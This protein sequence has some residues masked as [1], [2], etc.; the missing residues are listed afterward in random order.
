MKLIA[1]LI[2]LLPLASGIFNG[3][4]CNIIT[5]KSA[6]I[7]ACAATI[8]AAIL[9]TG[10]F[11][12]LGSN[13]IH[14]TLHR[15]FNITQVNVNW[16][17]YID[18]LS[19]IMFVIVTWI[20]ALVHI[21]SLGYMHDD[22][23]LPKFLSFLSFF[24]FFMLMLVSAD[25]FI[26]LF[27]GWEG[28]G[29]CSYLLIGYWYKRPAANAASIKAFVVNR[30]SDFAF[31]LGIFAIIVYSNNVNFEEVFAK[32]QSLSELKLSSFGFNYSVL[33]VI[34]FLLLVG[35]MGKS[36]QI[37]FHVW[38]PDAMEGPTP[39]SA[40]IHAATMVTAGIFLLARCSYIFEYSP[41][42]LQVVTIVGAITCLFAAS[43]AVAQVDIKK[44]I[45]YS[46]CSQ[47]GYMFFS[48]GISAYQASIFHLAT[49]AFFKAL[50]FLA[51][52]N[53][54]HAC[55]QQNIFEM[56][57]LRKKMPITYIG[58]WV[59][60]LAI[61]GI[62]PLAGFYSKDLILEFAF[63]SFGAGQ[64]GFYFGIITAVL[65]AIYSMKMII[66]VFHG[67]TRL[68]SDI[69][70]N[71]SE[72]PATMNIP[73]IILGLG[74][75]VTGMI[76]YYVL[77][78]YEVGTSTFFANSILNLRF[79]NKHVS[80]LVEMLPLGAGIAGILIAFSFYRNEKCKLNN[81]TK[82][83]NNLL[84]N[85]YY[86]DEIYDYLVVRNIK[87]LSDS[88]DII[89]K[90]LIDKFG[91]IGVSGII[92]IMA[93]KVSSFQTGYIFNY[94]LIISFALLICL[95]CFLINFVVKI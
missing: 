47:L 22:E 17:I 56:G 49:H 29:L 54:I 48:C 83:V 16:A 42:I 50:L 45:A 14:V 38:L 26:Q 86:F 64:L 27:F 40:L 3:I 85:K 32:A 78:L 67:K 94:A 44:I 93:S 28:V 62:F 34:C 72:A 57:G 84:K 19:S 24:T 36:A 35:C 8:T 65:T 66:F 12:Y 63:N 75:L 13:I 55:H 33:D 20:S 68:S 77:D 7:I 15:W 89:D 9:S 60:S 23:N 87:A 11:C 46:T 79:I 76:G 92:R 95:T 53:I 90:T 5:K 58:F 18:S 6:N 4:F 30:I 51:A 70:N 43:I 21:Y 59:G 91:P 82:F 80:T 88:M 37:G 2:V 25:N 31:I 61:I 39:V 73:L 52:G 81:E 1:T 41:N 10:V 71:I 69:Y 74:S